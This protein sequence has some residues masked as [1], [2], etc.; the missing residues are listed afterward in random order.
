MAP[1]R[2]SLP[3]RS[4]VGPLLI[5]AV[6]SLF[7]VLGVSSVPVSASGPEA[8]RSAASRYAQQAFAA[9]NAERTARGRVRLQRDACLQRF[10]NRQARRLASTS[11]TSLPHQP[12]GPIVRRCGLS[13]AGENLAYGFRTGREVVGAWMGSSGHRANI[14]DGR[15]RLMAIAARRSPEG[16]WYVAQVFG[17]RR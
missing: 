13:T 4:R 17:R 2:S 10:A 16:Q 11:N 6:T 1:H 8:A 15:Y 14:L 7:L 12:L 3:V 9:T 5:A